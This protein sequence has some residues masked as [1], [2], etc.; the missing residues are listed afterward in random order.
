MPLLVLD[1][2][3]PVLARYITGTGIKW[4]AGTRDVLYLCWYWNVHKINLKEA[5][6]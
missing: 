2:N 3:V 1:Q 5:N 6:T 4:Y